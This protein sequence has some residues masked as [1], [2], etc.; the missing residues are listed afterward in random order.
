MR[1]WTKINRSVKK[2]PF[3]QQN[4]CLLRCQEKAF[5]KFHGEI[6]P[7]IAHGVAQGKAD[8]VR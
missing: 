8:A 3:E 4:S 1:Q 7:R 5:A 6:P 2:T